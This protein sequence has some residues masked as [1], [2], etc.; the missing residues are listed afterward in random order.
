[1]DSKKFIPIKAID[2]DATL[3]YYTH[4]GNGELGAP[5]LRSVQRV[6]NWLAEG[7][8]VVIFTARINHVGDRQCRMI[9]EW[10]EQHIGQKLRVTNIKEAGFQE[11]YDDRAVQVEANTGRLTVQVAVKA[12]IK[13][14]FL[15]IRAKKKRSKSASV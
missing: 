11:I 13:A 7:Y 3:A 15:H 8:E 5:I 4:W 1:M 12:A 9:E 6:K 14:A 2:F 10:C